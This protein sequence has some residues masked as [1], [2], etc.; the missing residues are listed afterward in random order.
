MPRSVGLFAEGN[1]AA[2][3]NI[4]RDCAEIVNNPGSSLAVACYL[5]AG[6][7]AFSTLPYS[8]MHQ[9]RCDATQVARGELRQIQD[10][11][12]KANRRELYKE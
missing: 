9:R 6:T 10:Q 7:V 2:N 11:A 5:Y 8:T 12:R 1:E 3:Y 4:V